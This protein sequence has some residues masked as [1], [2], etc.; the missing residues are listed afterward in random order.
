[1][2]ELY[3]TSVI[4][5]GSAAEVWID[6]DAKLCKKYYRPDSI[7]ADGNTTKYQSMETLTKFFNNE[8]QWSTTLQSPNVLK[9]YEYGKL[10]EDAGYY[11]LQEYLGPDLL[12][13][14]MARQLHTLYPDIVEQVEHMFAILQEHDIYKLNNALSN[15]VGANGKIKMFDFKYTKRRTLENQEKEKYSI[16]EWLTKI[17][18]S[19]GNKLFKYI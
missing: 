16:T 15:M 14:Y 5:I 3:R 19:I 10:P 13:V 8:V 4:G 7:V 18:S 12:T 17:D 6:K 1:M 9:L 11:I 2:F